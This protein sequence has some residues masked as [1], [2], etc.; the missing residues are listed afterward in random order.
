MSLDGRVGI[1]SPRVLTR[2]Y[3]VFSH[4]A[5][6]RLFDRNRLNRDP[7]V[8]VIIEQQV[9]KPIRRLMRKCHQLDGN[10]VVPGFCVEGDSC[11]ELIQHQVTAIPRVRTQKT[12]ADEQFPL[13]KKGVYTPSLRYFQKNNSHNTLM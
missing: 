10:H 12:A 6:R 11:A 9:A 4:R 1:G 2:F 13:R 8:D 7:L 5:S 3:S